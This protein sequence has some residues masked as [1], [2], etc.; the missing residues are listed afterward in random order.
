[1]K[2]TAD[3]YLPFVQIMFKLKCDFRNDC[4]IFSVDGG[5]GIPREN[6]LYTASCA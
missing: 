4:N 3:V 5:T 6:D 2:R 1:M